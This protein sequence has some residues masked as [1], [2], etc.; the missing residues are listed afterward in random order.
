VEALGDPAD[1]V[2]PF[3]LKGLKE[4]GRLTTGR[5]FRER[6]QASRGRRIRADGKRVAPAPV[7]V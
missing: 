2:S 3:A 5:L 1:D 6:V 4:G 7:P